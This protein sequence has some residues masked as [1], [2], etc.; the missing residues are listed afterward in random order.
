MVCVCVCVWL[1]PRLGFSGCTDE[2]ANVDADTQGAVV[3]L[4]GVDAIRR[5]SSGVVVVVV[6][7]DVGV[8]VVSSFSRFRR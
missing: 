4:N 5:T 6:V 3:S 7:V 8:V 1:V 2:H